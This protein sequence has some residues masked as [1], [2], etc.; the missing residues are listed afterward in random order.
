[1]SGTSRQPQGIFGFL[2]P[3]LS[4]IETAAA[5]DVVAADVVEL[6]PIPGQLASEVTAAKLVWR[7]ISYM[8]F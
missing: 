8:L 4:A 6:T 2:S 5:G 3:D 1:M 7:L